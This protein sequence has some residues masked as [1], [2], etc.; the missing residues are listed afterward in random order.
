MS[1]PGEESAH[2]G[3]QD[4]GYAHD[5]DYGL[6]VAAGPTGGVSCCFSETVLLQFMPGITLHFCGTLF[7]G[8]KCL[9]PTILTSSVVAD[10]A[11][12]RRV[13]PRG[14]SYPLSSKGA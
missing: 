11:S 8:A 10:H 14:S 6:A 7:R 1:L 2:G 13:V 12:V 5:P 9:R 4:H 3:G